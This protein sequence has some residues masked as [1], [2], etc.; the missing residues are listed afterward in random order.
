M[1]SAWPNSRPA[2]RALVCSTA[3][4]LAVATSLTALVS[5]SGDAA[6]KANGSALFARPDS[7]LLLI[8]NHCP[9]AA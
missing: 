7:S 2:A 1:R 5:T 4:V 3:V 6:E 9:R 8:W